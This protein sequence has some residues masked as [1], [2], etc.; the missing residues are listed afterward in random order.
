MYLGGKSYFQQL[1][2][3]TKGTTVKHDNTGSIFIPPGF[4]YTYEI[5]LRVDDYE[6]IKEG[7][8]SP[9]HAVMSTLLLQS[10]T[11]STISIQWI[12][13]MKRIIYRDSC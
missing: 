5:S 10:Y 1:R 12:H 3:F 8:Y 4:L 6:G 7:D 9:A 13:D 11:S 2:E